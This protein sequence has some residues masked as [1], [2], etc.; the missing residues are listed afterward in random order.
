VR[1]KPATFVTGGAYSVCRNGICD[2]VSLN[3]KKIVILQK[4]S[5]PSSEFE[6]IH[7]RKSSQGG[8]GPTQPPANNRLTDLFVPPA[9][10]PEVCAETKESKNP[11][12]ETITVHHRSALEKLA[13]N[14]FGTQM[15]PVDL[16]LQSQTSRTR[17]SISEWWKSSINP[18]HNKM[19]SVARAAAGLTLWKNYEHSET[20]LKKIYLL[21]IAKSL[22]EFG[23]PIKRLESTVELAASSLNLRGDVAIVPGLLI[24]SFGNPET[25]ES[26]TTTIHCVRG[27]DVYRFQETERHI[28]ALIHKTEVSLE[29]LTEELNM[30]DSIHSKEVRRFSEMVQSI[31]LWNV[32]ICSLMC[33]PWELERW[34]RQFWPWNGHSWRSL[35]ISSFQKVCRSLG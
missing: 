22:Y 31:L 33:L 1:D 34:I 10:T 35:A 14:V 20:Q 23:C 29:D 5:V 8:T 27:L 18:Q 19:S 13:M 28:K 24:A 15:P 16:E 32:L 17:E 26:Q 9:A 2:H 11:D 25:E 6:G 3:L 21:K 4:M 7:R 30:L 12:E